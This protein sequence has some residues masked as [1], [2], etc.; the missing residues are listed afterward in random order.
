[1]TVYLVGAG[2]GD[3][4]LLTRRGAALLATADVVVYDRLIDPAVLGLARAGALLIDAGKR[5]A[6]DDQTHGSAVSEGPAR[7]G[8]INALLVEHGRTGRPVVRLKGGDP[9]LFGRGGEEAEALQAAGVPWEVVPGVT[10]AVAVPA[11]A[12]VPV[13]H[14]GLSTSVTMVTG[15]VGDDTASGGVDW[16]S[17]AKVGGTL[18]ILMGMA[19]RAA[20]AERLLAAGLGADTPV[21]VVEWGTL[22]AQRSARTTLAGLASVALGSPAVIVIGSVAGL[23][24]ASVAAPLAGR[25]VVVTRARAQ[26]DELGSALLAAGARVVELPMI[27]IEEAGEGGAALRRAVS[28]I[29]HYDWVAFTSANAVR[30]VA[31]LLRDGRSLGAARLAAVGRATTDGLASVYLAA[32]LVAQDASAEGLADAFA[33]APAPGGRVLFPRSASARA[34]LADGLRAKG[35]TVDEV[36]AYRTVPAPPPPAVLADAANAADVIIFA[37]PSTVS[38][39][40]AARDSAGRPLSLPPSVACIGPTTAR[41]A[42]AAGVPVAIEADEPSAPGLVSALVAHCGAPGDG[43]MPEANARP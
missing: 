19:T 17:L 27:A 34:A 20:I 39:F 18:V 22:P 23:G 7:Q 25:T 37:S 28:Q 35:W 30:R 2:P 12:G 3:P 21:S 5:P 9:F 38:A 26:N 40:L 29:H 1:M 32:D 11:A 31:A 42:R 6:W 33:A 16:E 4:G 8:D 41:S 24:L 15:H 10:S 36:D 14:R 13:T 43:E